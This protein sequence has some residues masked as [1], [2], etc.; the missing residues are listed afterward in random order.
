MVSY[1]IL[2]HANNIAEAQIIQDSLAEITI[3]VVPLSS[4]KS[5]DMDTISKI[6][7]E[8]LGNEINISIK[9][10]SSIARE[11][12]GKLKSVISSIN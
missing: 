2:K 11:N 10:V 12:S 4:F 8:K 9:P 6:A 5:A 7:R 1:N 3:L